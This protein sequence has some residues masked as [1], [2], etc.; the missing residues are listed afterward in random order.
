[1]QAQEYFKE[2]YENAL[3]KLKLAKYATE[4]KLYKD[5]IFLLHQ[6]CENLFYAVRLVFTQQNSKQHNLTKLLNSVKK[7][8][9]EFGKVF[10]QD[11]PEE[12]R[13]FE[14]IKAAYVN[15]RYDPDFVVTK[16]DID[17]L[18]PKVELLRGIIK[19]ICEEKIGEYDRME[20]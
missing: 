4:E 16:E 14:L 10:P 15:G 3:N 20:S 19:R 11:T 5:A 2:K 7:Y 9:D 17:A 1:Q 18:I 13:L 6:A 12:K 8:S